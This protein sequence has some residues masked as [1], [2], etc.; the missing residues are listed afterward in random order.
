MTSVTPVSVFCEELRYQYPLGPDSVVVDLGAFRGAFLMEMVTRFNSHVHA[1]EPSKEFYDAL[2]PRF[3]WASKVRLYNYGWHYVNTK[4]TLI[5][6][7]DAS[8]LF[9]N[10]SISED[11]KKL[12]RIELR[13]AGEAIEALQLRH[14]DLLKINIEGAEYDLLD[15]LLD[16]RLLDQVRYLQVQFHVHG[17]GMI[18]AA[19]R[20]EHI[21]ERLLATHDEQ[22]SFPFVWESWV[23]R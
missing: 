5:Q 8:S 23:R 15:H 21:R 16:N 19:K 13:E 18:G 4:A 10:S 6:A 1:F 7:G 9:E 22:W 17:G 20:R 11:D 3:R 2:V 14:I 12:V